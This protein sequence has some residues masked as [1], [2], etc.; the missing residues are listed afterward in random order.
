MERKEW[1]EEER[2][3]EKYNPRLRESFNEEVVCSILEDFW[4]YK[5]SDYENIEYPSL[6]KAGNIYEEIISTGLRIEDEEALKIGDF[7]SML[8]YIPFL[9]MELNYLFGEYFFPYLYIDRFYELKKLADYFDIELPPIPQKPDYKSRC[10]YYWELCKVFYLFRTKNNLTPD[11]LSAFMYDYAPNLLHTEEKSDIPQPSQAWFIGGLIRGYGE[12]WTTGFWQSNQ[13]TKKGD[14][15][16]HY[17]TSPVSAITCLWI[18]QTDGVIDPFFHYYSNTYISGKIDIPHITLKELQAD[19]YFS[20]HP[21]IR[22]NFQGVNGWSMSSEDYSELLRMIEAK[23]FDIDTLPKLYAPTLPK[24]INIEIERDVEQQLLEPLLNSMGWYENKDFI[25]QLPIHAGRGHRIFPDY[26]LHYGNK[27]DEEKAKVLIEAK[28]HM[29][30]NQEIEEA[31]LQARSYA[32]LLE[33]TV[34]VLCD[35]LSIIVY[36]KKDSFDRDGYKK[37]YWSEL[38]NPDLF[39]ELKNKLNI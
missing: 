29:K 21:L 7:D 22:K 23:G 37:Y 25:R 31:F 9:S 1:I 30:N 33:S 28:L 19:E 17:E 15:L 32:H 18:A 11:E 38:E 16:I 24:N 10:M 36:E 8:E 27:P 5:V 4:C 35:K 3:L 12:Q 6:D 14:I 20:K 39:N 34:I 2:L 26:A 13:E